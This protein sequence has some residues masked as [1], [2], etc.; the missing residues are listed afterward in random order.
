MK[1]QIIADLT[2]DKETA[3]TAEDGVRGTRKG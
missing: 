1:V 3:H 2:G